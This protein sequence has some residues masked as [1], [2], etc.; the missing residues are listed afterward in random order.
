MKRG[1]VSVLLNSYLVLAVSLFAAG[2]FFPQWYAWVLL[3]LAALTWLAIRVSDVVAL[4][5]H[6]DYLIL[7]LLDEDFAGRAASAYKEWL[8]GQPSGGDKR[9]LH[10]AA[11]RE[12]RR[13]VRKW[14]GTEPK[15][16]G[17]EPTA[18]VCELVWKVR[19][20]NRQDA[21]LSDP[22]TG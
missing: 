16:S 1:P 13:V 21:D 14:S 10:L 9:V 4:Q 2:Y 19:H 8:L 18:G 15:W 17:G 7:S 20:E 12:I 22:L 5:H 6:A 11:N 3:G